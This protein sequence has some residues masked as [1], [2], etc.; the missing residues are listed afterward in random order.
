MTVWAAVWAL[1]DQELAESLKLQGK[2]FRRIR[3]RYRSEFTKKWRIYWANKGLYMSIE[4][5][6]NVG[7][8]DVFLDIMAKE[9]D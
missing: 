1:K 8:R 9:V 5:L 4:S 6:D 7:E 3:I 2:R